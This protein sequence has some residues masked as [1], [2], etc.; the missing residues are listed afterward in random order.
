MHILILPTRRGDFSRD[1]RGGGGDDVALTDASVSVDPRCALLA[2]SLF[3]ARTSDALASSS[4]LCK[5]SAFCSAFTLA[6]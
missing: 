6:S 2:L 1:R 5:R 3:R 4:S